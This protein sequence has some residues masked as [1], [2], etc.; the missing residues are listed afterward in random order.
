MGVA[1]EIGWVP[2]RR[3][4]ASRDWLALAALAIALVP[5]VPVVGALVGAS[6]RMTL[7]AFAVPVGAAW[8]VGSWGARRRRSVTD[9]DDLV[10]AAV[11][12]AGQ[13]LEVGDVEGALSDLRAARRAATPGTTAYA[14]LWLQYANE[15]AQRRDGVRVSSRR[16]QEAMATEYTRIG[17]RRGRPALPIVALVIAAGAAISVAVPIARG[18]LSPVALACGQAQPILAAAEAAPRTT[19]IADRSL[20]HLV[21]DDPGVQ[22]T[23][24]RDGAM[25]LERAAATR[26]DPRADEELAAAGFVAAYRRDWETPDGHTLS[27]EIFQFAT[28]SGAAQFHREMTEYACRFSSEAFAGT[29]NETGL[30]VDYSVGDPVVEQL[31]WVDGPYRLVVA[32][33]YAAG[34]ADHAGITDLGFRAEKL[35]AGFR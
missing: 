35:L 12:A 15:E 23:L 5:V 33:S 19:P 14:D 25:G 16:T 8:I 21:L 28:P 7:V 11:H 9:P 3:A 34:P 18:A 22:A 13:R 17:S 24:V 27:A 31:A 1:I 4:G 6:L 2:L 30:Q 29:G 20:S 26:H 32:R 10:V